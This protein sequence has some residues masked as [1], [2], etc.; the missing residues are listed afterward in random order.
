MLEFVKTANLGHCKSHNSET[1]IDIEIRYTRFLV[2]GSKNVP[3]LKAEHLVFSGMYLLYQKSNY[4][5]FKIS[6]CLLLQC[7]PQL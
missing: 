4:G 2:N 1:E 5:H 7:K 3:N 6:I